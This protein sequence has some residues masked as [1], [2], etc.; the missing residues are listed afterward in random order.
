[1]ASAPP[2]D[3]QVE[4][5]EAGLKQNRGPGAPR[6]GEDDGIL[7]DVDVPGRVDELL[8]DGLGGG[9]LVALQ[10]AGQQAVDAAGDNGQGGVHD[11]VEG[12]AR[13]QGAELEPLDAA[14]QL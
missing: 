4:L 14:A 12:Q 5:C 9:V 7:L 2:G 8:M 6:E 10:G 11:Y 13:G 3:G 1:M